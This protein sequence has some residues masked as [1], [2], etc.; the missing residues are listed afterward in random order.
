MKILFFIALAFVGLCSQA[1]TFLSIHEPISPFCKVMA[2]LM[3]LFIVGAIG[4]GIVK[5]FGKKDKTA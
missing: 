2:S 1:Q 5:M 3:G 4:Y